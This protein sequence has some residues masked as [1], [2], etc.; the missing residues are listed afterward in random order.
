[1]K[2][3]PVIDI[4][5]G[6]VVHAVKGIRKEYLPLQSTLVSSTAPLEVAQA[7]KNLG[8]TELYIA[9]LDAIIDCSTNFQTLKHIAQETGLKLMVDAGVTGIKRAQNLL[10]CGVSELI[11]GTETLQ[12]KAFV[13]EA[14]RLFGSDRVLVS[15]D[16][17]DDKVVV[18]RGFD[19]SSDPMVLL[20][21]LKA[22][23]VSR[24]IVL[25][26]SRVGSNEGVNVDLL[27]KV[28]EV[29]INVYVGGGVRDTQ[30]LVELQGLGVLGA[31]L[32]TALHSGEI[33]VEELKQ[34]NM[35]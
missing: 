33:R 4:L 22:I 24:V 29:G 12:T 25:D 35:L 14:V 19:G 7:F 5:N 23:G 17:K 30:D 2:V 9:D 31:L 26:L 32:A 20:R 16:L 10:A 11:I 34:Q 3:I 6:N 18:K 1:M 21:E 15:L 13:R 28:I 8:F 27:K